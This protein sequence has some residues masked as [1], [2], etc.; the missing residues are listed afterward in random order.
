MPKRIWTG[1]MID[2]FTKISQD[3]SIQHE[4]YNFCLLLRILWSIVHKGRSVHHETYYES[5][6][7]VLY[8]HLLIIS[9]LFLF[10]QPDISVSNVLF[11]SSHNS[12]VYGLFIFDH[13]PEWITQG[14]ISSYLLMILNF[15]HR[16]MILN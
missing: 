2:Y 4:T 7:L 12:M 9:L 14:L 11:C 3:R 16:V 13:L 5:Q 6:L 1:L 10:G 15:T 8:R